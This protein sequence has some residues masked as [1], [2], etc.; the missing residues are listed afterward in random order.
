VS[1]QINLFN[2]IFLKQK[3]LFSAVTM[4]QGLG[5]ILLGSLAMAGYARF[6]LSSLTEEAAAMSTQ[7]KSTKAQAAQVAANYAPRQKSA[8][9]DEEITQAEAELAYQRQAVDVVQKGGLGNTTGYSEYMGAFSRQIVSGLWVTGFQ[10]NGA[11]NEI[12]LRGRSL[13]PELVPAYISRLRQEPAMKGK[14]FSTL[15]MQVP[16]IDL[17]A[18]SGAAAANAAAA[19]P[20]RGPAGY[21]EFSLR[22]T[23]AAGAPGQAS[24]GRSMLSPQS[25]ALPKD[26][27]EL[28]KP[29]SAPAAQSGSSPQ[30][31]AMPKQIEDFYGIK[32]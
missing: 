20:K 26:L 24:D 9:I 2:P 31:P 29:K 32:K 22:S 16:E 14:S 27:E 4:A 15:A 17:P 23:D 21:I 7:L 12:E 30:T 19:A 1:Q 10:I 5:L 8:S 13:Q 28:T 6:Q 3:K 18:A 11:G 25:S